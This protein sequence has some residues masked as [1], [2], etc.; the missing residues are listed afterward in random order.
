MEAD[1][2]ACLR[3]KGLSPD[4]LET[5]DIDEAGNEALRAQYDRLVPVLLWGEDELCRFR[6]NLA[7]LEQVLEKTSGT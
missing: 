7:A 4:C 1:I 3:A 5:R 2:F 6:L